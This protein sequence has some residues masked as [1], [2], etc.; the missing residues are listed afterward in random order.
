MWNSY[1]ELR[2]TKLPTVDQKFYQISKNGFWRGSAD[3]NVLWFYLFLPHFHALHHAAMC[4]VSSQEYHM[5]LNVRMQNVLRGRSSYS[6]KA[7]L[8]LFLSKLTRISY[9]PNILI[10]SWTASGDW[11]IQSLILNV[12]KKKP[13][14]LKFHLLKKI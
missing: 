1:R 11:L 8:W 2:R 4:K 3:L 10:T 12:Y 7:A 14:L 13:P 9:Q 5:S 6:R